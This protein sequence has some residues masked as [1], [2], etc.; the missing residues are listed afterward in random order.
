MK[1]Q[2]ISEK[3][4]YSQKSTYCSFPH[5][6]KSDDGL[7][8]FF[9]RAGSRSY[10]AA[11]AD[12]ATHHDPDSEILEIRSHD[13]G[14]TWSKPSVA[15]QSSYGVNDPAATLLPD[16]SILLRFVAL[17]IE[18][19]SEYIDN[20]KK[21]FSHRP[22]HGLVTQV[23]GNVYLR[24]YRHSSTWEHVGDDS[25]LSIGPVCSRD[26]VVILED[27][28]L[29]APV[30]CGAPQRCDES[31]VIRSYD[32]GLT[33]GLPSLVATDTKGGMS[34]LHGINYNETSLLNNGNGSLYALIR[35]DTSFHTTD[36][37]F[38]PVGGCGY[39]YISRT[40]DSGLSWTRPENTGLYGQPGAIMR[41]STGGLLATYGCRKRPFSIS[42]AFSDDEAKTWH[43]I[44]PISEEIQSWDCG[45]PFTIE[46]SPMTFITVFYKADANGLR[47]IYQVN[48][49]M[50]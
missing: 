28:S 22:E 44:M 43:T 26:P 29:M 47:G 35:G 27:N 39:L 48:W 10:H 23:H 9:R 24:R 38:M 49:K 30:Y 37:H 4:I 7:H 41:L 45:Y 15:Y 1:I 32:N 42:V 34:Q 21:I 11:I 19:S 6:L 12:L 16:G 8:V 2:V 18:K 14:E 17:R 46:T 33:W 25:C 40:T 50:L 5:I 31:Y 36:Q 20:G 3:L 13:N